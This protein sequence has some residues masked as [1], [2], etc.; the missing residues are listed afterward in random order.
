[1]KTKIMKIKF[2]EYRR[3]YE[4][5]KLSKW[6]PKIWTTFDSYSCLFTFNSNTWKF[7]ELF[8]RKKINYQNLIQY[9]I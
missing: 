6:D 1:M 7:Y 2:S 4:Y 9:V 8:E 3:Y 5:F